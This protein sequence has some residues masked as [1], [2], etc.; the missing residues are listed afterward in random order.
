MS[1]SSLDA[2]PCRRATPAA[3][4]RIAQ[5][6][7]APAALRLRGHERR[8]AVDRGVVG[9][10]YWG[11]NLARNFTALPATQLRW[12]CDARAER[13][14]ALR[15]AA[16]PSARFTADLDDLLADPTLDA[17]VLATPGADA[18]PRSPCA[19]SRPASTASSRSR[20]RSRWPTPSAPSTPQRRSG[21]VLM[22][23][24]LLAVPPG[25]RQAQ[26]DRRL[27]R[28][29]RHPLH[30]RQPP[31]PRQA[32]RRRERA[33]VL[34]AHDVSVAAAPRR[35]GALRARGARRVLHARGRRGRRL[36]LPALPVRARRAPAPVV[37]G[38]AQ[39]AALH[40]R[41]L[42]ADG[43]V[44]RHGARAQD[45]R[46]RQG[47]RRERRAPT[48]STS[49]ARATSG[50]RAVPTAEPLRLE[51]EHFV[52][53]VREGRDA[54]LRR[55]AAACAS[56][57]CSRGCRPRWTRAAAGP[58]AASQTATSAARAAADDL[59]GLIARR[60]PGSSGSPGGCARPRRSPGSSTPRAVLA[61]SP[62]GGGPACGSRPC[63][64]CPRRARPA[65]S[66]VGALAA[67]D[68]EVPRGRAARD[69]AAAASTSSPRP[70]CLVVA[71]R[72]ARRPSAQRVEVRQLHA[73]D[74]R[75]QLVQARVVADVLVGDLVPA[76]R[77]SAACARGRRARRRRS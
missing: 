31:E 1:A 20:W 52:D 75:L 71:R 77:G 57:A 68:V 70:A 37:A 59:V 63:A 8:S 49:P 2:V 7:A 35:R 33:V 73:Q 38:P 34:G 76:S 13:P 46:L 28:A 54:D 72:R 21:T 42:Q 40:G 18:T 36:R 26:G 47:L 45:H 32:A 43:D 24:H 17:V 48:A 15:A 61:P 58:G 44:R 16:S 55:R 69:A 5:G 27:R 53:C 30:L 41:R 3:S 23:G 29:R 67:H 66:V 19:C 62:A 39:G 12:C 10:G 9:L 51:C 74:R 50:R 11:P 64:R 25:R 60:A 56:C 14:R 6:A 4:P 65:A 22:V